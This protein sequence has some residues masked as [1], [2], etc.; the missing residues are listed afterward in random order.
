[1]QFAADAAIPLLIALVVI[2]SQAKGNDSF[3]SFL[4]GAGEGLETAM[5]LLPTLIAIIM[6]VE[7]FR[8]SGG[9]EALTHLLSPLF[10]LAGIP[11]ELAPLALLRPISYSGSLA[12]FQDLLRTYGADSLIGKTASVI[13]G[14]SET[15]LYVMA[16]YFGATAVKNTKN[17]LAISL[18][19]TFV[20]YLVS[21]LAVRLFVG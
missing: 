9:L 1:M 16:V 11:P 7:M 10:R 12:L 21:V 14:S 20:G 18:A 2:W 6:A 4:K 15:A 17:T 8:V 13:E 19:V 3:A 5:K